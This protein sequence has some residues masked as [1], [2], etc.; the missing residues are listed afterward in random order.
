MPEDTVRVLRILEYVGPRSTIEKNLERTAVPLN[1]EHVYGVGDKETRIRSAILGSFPEILERAQQQPKPWYGD[2]PLSRSGLGT[3]A[4]PT[5]ASAD[6]AVALNPPGQPDERPLVDEAAVM[7]APVSAP[8]PERPRRWLS[9]AHPKVQISDGVLTNEHGTFR[10][11]SVYKYRP[12]WGTPELVGNTPYRFTKITPDEVRS[13][14]A[15]HDRAFD[16]ERGGSSDDGYWL[17]A[18]APAPDPADAQPDPID[19]RPDPP[20]PPTEE[21]ER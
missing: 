14:I 18:C 9:P 5:P 2:E 10:V 17:A 15:S 19:T 21:S 3:N 1:G 16:L 12:K 4:T 6:P 11:G 20:A 13:A 8:A 7:A